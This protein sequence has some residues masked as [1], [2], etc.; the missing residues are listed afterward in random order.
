M[1]IEKVK[2]L[3]AKEVLLAF[4]IVVT[5]AASWG[6]LLLRN[7]Y[8]KDKQETLKNE[9]SQLDSELDSL[10]NNYSKEIYDYLAELNPSHLKDTSYNDFFKSVQNEK[11]S[12]EIYNRIAYEDSTFIV[13]VTF[14]EFYNTIKKQISNERV[15]YFKKE[16]TQKQEALLY[17]TSSIWDNNKIKTVFQYIFIVLIILAY[18]VR[19]CY[20]LL[21]WALKTLRT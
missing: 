16:K 12:K 11:Y 10:S 7:E 6:L 2:K 15:Y 19:I 4:G 20:F 5:V 3:I 13:D 1:D 8:Y 18:P 9:I 21:K 17:T 14:T